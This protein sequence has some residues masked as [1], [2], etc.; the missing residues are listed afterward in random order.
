MNFISVCVEGTKGAGKTSTVSLVADSLACRGIEV[1]IFEPFRAANAFAQENGFDGA[2]AMANASK[3]DNKREILFLMSGIDAARTRA[4]VRARTTNKPV[5]LILDRGWMTINMHLYEG[6]WARWHGSAAMREIDSIWAQVLI[7]SER[8]VFLFTSPR[9]TSQRKG[10]LGATTGLET[11]Q[12]LTQDYAK[13]MELCNMHRQKIALC[14]DTENIEQ[15]FVVRS[16][17]N[18][19]VNSLRDDRV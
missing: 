8:T 17:E 7:G 15:A 5:V 10:F 2:W 13:R 14:L 16:V 9:V 3:Y 11:E 18:Y 19:I 6:E 1:T 4:E 12:K